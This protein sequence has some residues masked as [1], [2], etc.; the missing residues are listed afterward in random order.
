MNDNNMNEL[1]TQVEQSLNK[2]L[3]PIRLPY[4]LGRLGGF[5]FDALSFLTGIKFPITGIRIKK[6]CA[7]TQLD[8]TLVQSSDF[9][10]PYSLAD[11]LDRT[12]RN[13]FK[14]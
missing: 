3:P 5:G 10:A 14:N 4:W 11:G 6:F 9:K 1:V 2:R 7:S 8:A 13:E 12:L